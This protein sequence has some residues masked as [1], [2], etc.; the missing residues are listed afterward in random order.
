MGLIQDFRIAARMLAKNKAWTAV[1]LLAL[2]LGL[3]AN[4]AIFSVVGLMI[5]VPLPYP[6]AAQLVYIPQTNTTKG[7]SQSSVSLQDVRDWQSA[8]G[9]ASIAAYR[10]RPMAISGEGEPQQLPAMQVTPEFFP[11]LG[12]KPALGRAFA[13]NEGPESDARVAVL[14][15]ALWQGTYRGEPGVLGREVRLNGGNYTIVGVMPQDFHFLYRKADLWV[16]LSLE[17]AQRERG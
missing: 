6:D 7:F 13:P 5:Q 10:S 12:V 17:P 14:S 4:V 16:P 11:T 9:I 15:Y 1:A 3:G 8:Q 2:A